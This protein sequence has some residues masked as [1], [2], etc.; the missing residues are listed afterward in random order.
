MRLRFAIYRDPV[1]REQ[2]DEYA[3][4]HQVGGVDALLAL[5]R[6]ESMLEYFDEMT[7]T[8]KEVPNVEI[9]RELDR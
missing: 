5:Q 2:V 4:R 8:W 6:S 3:L 9:I 7:Q 1:T